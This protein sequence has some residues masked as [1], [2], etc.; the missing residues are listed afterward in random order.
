MKPSNGTKVTI[1]DIAKAVQV[2]TATVSRYLNGH[3]DHMSA[4]TRERIA[5]AIRDLHYLPMTAAR[6]LKLKKSKMIG[7]VVHT[8]KYSVGSQTVVGI[9]NVCENQGYS[10]IIYASNNDPDL[11]QAALQNCLEQ[12]VDGLIVI[13]VSQDV[14]RYIEIYESGTPLVICTR[15]LKGWPYGAVA[16]RHKKLI[17]EMV[18][19]LWD[20]GYERHLM[21][22][23][24][25]TWHKRWMVQQFM[26]Y[27]ALR[28]GMTENQAIAWVR[29]SPDLIRQ[30]V[31]SF[32]EEFPD[33]RKAVFAVNTQVL[34]LLLRELSRMA[35]QIPQQLGVCGYDVIGWSELV[36][37]GISA[38][39][40]PM[41]QMGEIAA[42]LLFETIN[43]GKPCQKKR[44][45][46]GKI[47]YRSS[48]APVDRTLS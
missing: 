23:D 21:L 2:S 15:S 38:I 22:V 48:T 36:P 42:E 16:V 34:F 20:R 29:N 41:Q 37:P 17:G 10:T 7:V 44:W 5:C 14:S 25:P 30:A 27:S 43:S 28:T 40:Q 11:E 39:E 24:E 4:Q 33:R 3:Y 1:G 9:R 12:Q 35:I 6:T 19:H 32:M 45:L 31:A 47:Y 18:C 46:E 8:L 13:P 26:D